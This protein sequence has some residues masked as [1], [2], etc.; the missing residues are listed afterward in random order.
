MRLSWHRFISI[1]LRQASP[2]FACD[3]VWVLE[4][5]LK[6]R[7]RYVGTGRREI[8]S[9]DTARGEDVG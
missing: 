2:I 6:N 8:A 1:S 3:S 5:G 9:D 7:V 4:A